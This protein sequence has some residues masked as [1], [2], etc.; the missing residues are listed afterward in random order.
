MPADA[1]DGSPKRRFSGATRSAWNDH[2]MPPGVLHQGIF[3]LYFN[4]LELKTTLK[5]GGG[6]A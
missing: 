5:T 4:E 1:M 3:N 6:Q 2:R